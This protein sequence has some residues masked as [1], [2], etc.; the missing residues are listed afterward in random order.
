MQLGIG[1][2]QFGLDY[3]VANQGGK[4]PEA[5]VRRILDC[6]ADAGI[7][8]VD[9]AAAYGEA[10]VVLG[11]CLPR[12]PRFRVVTKTRPLRGRPAGVAAA[13]WIAEGFQF[14]LQRLGLDRVDGLLVHHSADLLGEDGGAVLDYLSGLKQSGKVGKIGFSAYD[15]SSVDAAMAT[16]DFDLVQIPVN[17]LD[18][19]L[20]RSGHL[21]RLRQAG[22]E[23][24]VRSAFLQ[25]VLLMAPRELPQ[26][27]AP[28]QQHLHSW[29]RALDDSGMTPLQGAFAFM[30][31][32]DVDVIIIGVENATQ[33]AANCAAFEQVAESNL[34][35][36]TFAIDD[37]AFLDPSRWRL[38][39]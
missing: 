3:G 13:D 4:S 26:Y 37:E 39:A 33:L 7:A 17:V 21:L 24:H 10:E 27:F 22:V 14:S 2:V 8:V 16:H 36:S 9:T 18:Q 19:R 38:A 12:P 29:H 30:R 28:L 23:I 6:A 1:T 25:G 5:E 34:Q 32:L 35:F 15:A 11:R 20:L 31:S